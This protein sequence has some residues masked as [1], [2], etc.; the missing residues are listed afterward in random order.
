MLTL[1][2]I[3]SRWVVLR[4]DLPSNTLIVVEGT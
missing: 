3:T 2:W 4:M 1:V